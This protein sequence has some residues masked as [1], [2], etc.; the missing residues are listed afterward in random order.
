MPVV[1]NMSTPVKQQFWSHVESITAQER[2]RI[3]NTAAL[4]V[5]NRAEKTDGVKQDSVGKLN[6]ADRRDG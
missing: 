2:N 3:E 4:K 6:R 1:K 5:Q